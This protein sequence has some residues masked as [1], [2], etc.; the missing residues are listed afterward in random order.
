MRCSKKPGRC[1][2]SDLAMAK[3]KLQNIV[4][5]RKPATPAIGALLNALGGD[6]IIEDAEGCTILG[7][8]LTLDEGS[9]KYPVMVEGEILGH[10]RGA[11]ADC[12]S[13]AALLSLLMAREAETKQLS[14]EVLNVYREINLIH[15]FSEKLATLLD[16]VSV[17]QAAAEQACQLVKSSFGAILLLDDGSGIFEPV[18]SVPNGEAIGSGIVAGKGLIGAIAAKG[19]AEIVND[20]TSDARHRATDPALSS[21]ICVPLKLKDTIRGILVVGSAEPVVYTAGELKLLSTLSLQ[22]AAALEN[23]LLHEKTLEAARMQAFLQKILPKSIAEEKLNTGEVQPKYFEDVTVCFTDFVGFSKS[24]MVM[25]AEDVV[26]ELNTYFTAFDRIVERYG[27]EKLK[28]IGDS[29]MFVS[30]LPTRRP[31]NPIDAVLAALEMAETVRAM[32][33]QSRGKWKVRIGLHTGPVIAGVVGIH[34]FAF[35]VWG[36]T[37]NLASRME[38]C[39]KPNRVNI[40]ELTFTR[41]KDFLALRARGRVITKEGLKPRMYQVEGVLAELLGGGRPPPLFKR[42]YN[43]YFGDSPPSFPEHLLAAPPLPEPVLV[44]SAHS[45]VQ[46]KRGRK[47]GVPGTRTVRKTSA[48][49]ASPGD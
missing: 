38:S 46:R 20:V 47:N 30:G 39:G 14:A 42:R 32:A 35:D 27:V 2:A 10:V 41:V 34:K 19:N 4:G 21:L 28:T 49:A 33:A 11:A 6:I 29:Y 26:Q 12:E 31:A 13:L 43:L 9:A 3:V 37:V 17:A 25:A 15:G 45:A 16:K 23:A 8:G 7:S 1:F 36:E 48:L 44:E 22:T 5:R 18:A 40:S 24:T